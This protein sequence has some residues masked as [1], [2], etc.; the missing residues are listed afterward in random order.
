M[1]IL[2]RYILREVEA[3]CGRERSRGPQP[4]R[5][6]RDGLASGSPQP[7]SRTQ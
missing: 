3:V 4:A 5:F 7:K 6:W 1:R 2:T